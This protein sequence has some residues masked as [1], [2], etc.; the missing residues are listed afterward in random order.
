MIKSQ[1]V[2]SGIK[3]PPQLFLSGAEETKT[4]RG[5]R[6]VSEV[7]RVSLGR[8]PVAEVEW[9]L[10]FQLQGTSTLQPDLKRQPV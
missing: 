7:K 8:L 5:R 6:L 2:A 3:I 4:S 10:P 9:F 1:R